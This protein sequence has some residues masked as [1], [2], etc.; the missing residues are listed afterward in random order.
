MLGALA[1]CGSAPSQ[2]SRFVAQATRLC[3]DHRHTTSEPVDMVALR[4]VMA[5]LRSN[6]HLPEVRGWHGYIEARNRLRRAVAATRAGSP[7]RAK[8]RR[9]EIALFKAERRVP[10]IGQ[11]AKSPYSSL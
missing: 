4:E 10:G 6:E 3:D 8:V 7:A 5:L 11:C 9:E 2:A 1:G